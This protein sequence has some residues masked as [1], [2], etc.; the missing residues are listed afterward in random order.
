MKKHDL[1]VYTSLAVNIMCLII[2]QT[3]AYHVPGNDDFLSSNSE[4]MFSYN[5]TECPKVWI[6]NLCRK[7]QHAF[8][9]LGQYRIDT[10]ISN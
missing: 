7:K 3:N 10:K 4:N 1:I 2:L 8:V 5:F 9:K 6:V